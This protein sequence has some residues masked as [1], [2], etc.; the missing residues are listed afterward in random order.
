MM[1]EF[2]QSGE[3]A[4]SNKRKTEALDDDSDNGSS[5]KKKNLHC[6]KVKISHQPVYNRHE[7]A[8]KTLH[9]CF[10]ND[11]DFRFDQKTTSANVVKFI[12]YLKLSTT[13]AESGSE[14]VEHE[15]FGEG[16]SK[17]EAKNSCCQLALASLFPDSYRVPKKESDE[18]KYEMRKKYEKLVAKATSV[19]KSH[20][21]ILNELDP[22]FGDAGQIVVEKCEE[23][24]F[25]FRY[26]N[27]YAT[28]DEE[29]SEKL[30]FGY[31]EFFFLSSSLFLFF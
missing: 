21:Q 20:S 19:G 2:V 8:S 26:V 7:P 28:A 6:K 17:K 22:K 3:D 30:V 11:L 27:H 5:K 29:S 24:K 18:Y 23:Q 1:I 13:R 12:C 14:C 10:P 25:C 16:P 4:E 31:G 15:F 9:D